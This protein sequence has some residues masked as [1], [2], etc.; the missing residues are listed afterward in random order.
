M[1]GS[2]SLDAIHV[3]E[4][5]VSRNDLGEVAASIASLHHCMVG[6]EDMSVEQALLGKYML[7]RGNCLL[8]ILPPPA[9]DRMLRDM[10]RR[11][12]EEIQDA[13]VDIEEDFKLAIRLYSCE[14]PI[15]L[16]TAVNSPFYSRQRT[17]A[18]TSNHLPFVKIMMRAYDAMRALPA[19]A[20]DG[21]AYRGIKPQGRYLQQ[22]NT[23]ETSFAVGSRWSLAAF[24]SLSLDR[25]YAL[26]HFAF[27]E[28]GGILCEFRGASG[29]SIRALSAVPVPGE[30]EVLL[31]PP[32]VF[33]IRSCRKDEALNLVII[34]LS[35]PLL[36]QK[37]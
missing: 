32:S 20:Y 10:I 16:Y 26:S 29:I 33:V 11:N 5:Q 2:N 6:V 22:F 18:V 24:S 3:A 4:A 1:S 7:F 8:N 34:E 25:D 9:S 14:F 17:D 28:H 27:N 19:F 36:T 13:A 30:D 23:F 21:P 37:Y 35:A 31:K 12:R 15:P